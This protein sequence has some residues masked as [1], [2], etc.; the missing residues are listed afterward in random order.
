[1]ARVTVYVPDDV[2]ARMDEAGEDLNWSALAQRAFVEA[3]LSRAVRK[4]QS[5]M[6]KVI[7][8]LRASKERVQEADFEAGKT[9]GAQWAKQEAEY[10]ELERLSKYAEDGNQPEDEATLRRLIDPSEKLD[11]RDFGRLLGHE[12]PSE[13]YVIGFAEGAVEVFDE[14]AD[15]L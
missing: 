15:K 8:R 3:A 2:K 7:E 4:D 10:D 9:A 1:M 11:W 13:N 12:N 5:N 6:D 14:V